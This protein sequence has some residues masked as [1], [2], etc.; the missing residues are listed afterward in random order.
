M[1]KAKKK[2]VMLIAAAVLVVGVVVYGFIPGPISVETAAVTVGPMRVIVEEEGETSVRHTYTVTSPVAAYARRIRLEAGDEVI[3]GQPLVELEPPRSLVLDPRSA[4][5]AVERVRSAEATV[6]QAEARAGYVVSE[7]ERVRR[8]HEGGSVPA[9][10]LEH[11]EM[12]AT[13]A[14]AALDAAR[15]E[16]AAARAA[17]RDRE[18][19][20]ERAATPAG[21]VSR[22]VRSPADG[23]VL[24]LH[25]RSEGHVQ[26]GEPLLEIGDIEQL[27][28]RVS[29]LSQDAVRIV[30]GTPVELDR[31]GGDELLAATVT[32]VERQGQVVVSALGVEERRVAVVAELDSP[33]EQRPGLGSGYRVLARFVVWQDDAVLQ[34]PTGA[35][36]RGSDGWELFV[37][38]DN[39]AVR[40]AVGVGRQA[41]LTAQI[42]S[43]LAEGEVVV[44]HPPSELSDGARVDSRRRAGS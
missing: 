7:R 36:F 43:G 9:N 32:R 19:D 16:L 20:L 37:V 10:R 29:V 28:V 41:G 31:W 30:P 8:L 25:R 26:P 12:E 22:V 11:A 5:Q 2:R 13:V 14:L 40:R 18:S 6:A 23:Q 15:A 4:E 42:T 3:S 34:V 27:E 35:L 24:R 1:T 21:R 38:E 33:I 17:A 44:V 39:R